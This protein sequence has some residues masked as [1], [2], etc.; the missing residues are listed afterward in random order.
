[1]A[2]RGGMKLHTADILLHRARLF[3]D[4]E[5]LEAA[6]RLIGET[7]YHRRDA[8]LADARKALGSPAG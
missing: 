4:A 7:G 2:E 5:A 6:G 1:M 3:R 8:E